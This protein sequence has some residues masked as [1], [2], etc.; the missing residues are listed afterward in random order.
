M[1][2][3]FPCPS[4]AASLLPFGSTPRL[5]LSLIVLSAAG[6]FGLDAAFLIRP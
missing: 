6:W 3:F 4:S 1:R 2:P 5:L